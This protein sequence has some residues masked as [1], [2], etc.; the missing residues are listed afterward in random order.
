M[1]YYSSVSVRPTRQFA[2]DFGRRHL[3]DLAARS[4]KVACHAGASF[5]S[6]QE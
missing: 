4:A 2:G 3:G 5:G 1:N 6:T